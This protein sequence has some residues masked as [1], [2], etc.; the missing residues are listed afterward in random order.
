V[1]VPTAVLGTLGD[2]LLERF[3]GHGGVAFAI[4]AIAAIA[5]A[6]FGYYFLKGVLA[7]IVVAH[8]QGERAPGL[9]QMAPGLPY[10]SMLAC[11]VLLTLGVAIGMVLLVVPG[12]LFGTYFGL[13]PVLVEVERRGPIKAL[14]RSLELVR[15]NFWIVASVL[16]MTLAGVALLSLPLKLAAGAIFPG[17]AGDPLEEG[18]GLLLAGILVKPIGA[19]TTVELTLDL[20]AGRIPP[21]RS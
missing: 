2:R 18:V 15:G 6:G 3:V 10:A 14:R 11:D 21:R 1:L 19:V 13:A 17:G 16:F 9:A 4:L 7:H 5:I 8:R 12:L 20:I